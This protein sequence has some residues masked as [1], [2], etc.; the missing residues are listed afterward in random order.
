[1]ALPLGL[2][3]QGAVAA[4]PYIYTQYMRTHADTWR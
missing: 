1:M 3:A 2:K 4:L